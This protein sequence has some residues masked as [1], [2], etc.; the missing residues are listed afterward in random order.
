MTRGARTMTRRVHAVALGSLRGARRILARATNSG[1]GLLLLALAGGLVLLGGC[2]PAPAPRSRV[3]VERGAST[4]AAA[5]AALHLSL[6]APASP[7]AFRVVL[8][9][10]PPFVDPTPLPHRSL[11]RERK[12]AF[13][14][15]GIRRAWV[16]TH[17]A[18]RLWRMA[19]REMDHIRRI[20]EAG[21]QG[22]HG[23]RDRT[24]RLR[25]RVSAHLKECVV[26][27]EGVLEVPGAPR[28]ARLRLA[29]YLR[30]LNPVAAVAH[31]KVLV[32]TERDARLRQRYALDWAQLLLQLGHPHRAAA[33]LL[34]P[35]RLATSW[36]ALLLRGLALP[37]GSAI[38]QRSLTKLMGGCDQMAVAQ[39]RALL[40]SL[41]ALLIGAARPG[42]LIARLAARAP[43]CWAAVTVTAM[44]SGVCK[45]L[46]LR[47]R[48]D[49]AL[50]VVGAASAAVRSQAAPTRTAL[51]ALAARLRRIAG[52]WSPGERPPSPEAWKRWLGQR[53]QGWLRCGGAV[54]RRLRRVVLLARP[55]GR[56]SLSRALVQGARGSTPAPRAMTRCLAQVARAWHSPGWK[57]ASGGA[58]RLFVRIVPPA[59]SGH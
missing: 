15:K 27:L 14:E 19:N 17:L 38:K 59:D 45:A 39:R 49:A 31:F 3:G 23:S 57:A 43:R 5:R 54:G 32:R 16:H 52:P 41:P 4:P 9:P 26:L 48:P 40:L 42:G 51:R 1:G 28:L 53:L 21:E 20:E 33:V 2:S 11:K 44:V 13:R 18:A 34:G 36:R 8:P 30:R 46:L 55:A 22:N 37:G 24:A 10:A 12:L 50:A 7:P 29:Y 56:V 35:A 6:P 47:G 25:R 58:Q